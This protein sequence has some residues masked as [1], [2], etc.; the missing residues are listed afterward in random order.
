M[1]SGGRLD[2]GWGKQYSGAYGT[3]FYIGESMITYGGSGI[4]AKAGAQHRIEYRDAAKPPVLGGSVTPAPTL[5]HNPLLTGCPV[6]GNLEIDQD[7]TCDD[8]NIAD[9]DGC[10]SNCLTEP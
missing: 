6:C 8:G 7:E 10:D 4:R 9:G 1:N 5:V 2:S 3:N